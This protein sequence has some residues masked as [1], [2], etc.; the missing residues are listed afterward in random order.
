MADKQG[1]YSTLYR[2]RGYTNDQCFVV[3]F[4]VSVAIDIEFLDA[5]EEATSDSM[6]VTLS[7]A[8]YVSI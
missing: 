2:N 3:H 1:F 7:T 6:Y 8:Q 5:E 4:F